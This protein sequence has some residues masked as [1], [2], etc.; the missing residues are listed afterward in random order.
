M[1]WLLATLVVVAAAPVVLWPLIRHW[2]PD[3]DPEAPADPREARLRELEELELDVA[4]GR[5]SRLEA[6][7]RRAELQP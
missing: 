2:Q 6:D 1:T 5:L 7:R 4:S 3:A